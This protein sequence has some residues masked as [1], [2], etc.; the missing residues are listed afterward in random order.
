MASAGDRLA[1]PRDI[2]TLENAVRLMQELR[3]KCSN[4]ALTTPRV[5]H[6]IRGFGY[7]TLD[8]QI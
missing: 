1:S 6:Q 2:H 5:G 3:T 8:A 4:L 7:L